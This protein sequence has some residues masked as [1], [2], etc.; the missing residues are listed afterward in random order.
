MTMNQDGVS[1]MKLRRPEPRHKKATLPEVE[2]IRKALENVMTVSR[3][4]NS[5]N[6]SFLGKLC[7]N[8]EMYGLYSPTDL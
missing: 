4:F 8:F 3:F 1:A 6:M 7:Y 2:K 5:Y